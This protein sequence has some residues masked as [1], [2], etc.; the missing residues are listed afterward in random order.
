MG[1]LMLLY[2][3]LVEVKAAFFTLDLLLHKRNFLLR[4]IALAR[5]SWLLW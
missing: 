3:D 5:Y 4:K 2:S 1:G